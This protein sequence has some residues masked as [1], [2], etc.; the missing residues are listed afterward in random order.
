MT[1]ERYQ[2]GSYLAAN[3]DWHAADAPYKARWIADLLDHNGLKPGHATEIG[4]GSGCVLANLERL[5]P[6]TRLVGCEI[7]RD[8]HAIA[9]RQE[10][11]NIAAHLR[12]VLTEG[13]PEPT[14]L[15]MA[16]DVIEHV[17]DSFAFLRGIR[18][19]AEWKLLHIPLELSVQGLLR[20]RSLMHARRHLG[21]IHYYCRDTALALLSDCG[22]EVRDWRYTHGAEQLPGRKLRT[23]LLNVPRRALRMVDENLSVRVLGGASMLVLAR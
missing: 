11:P 4:S 17:E 22:M 19:L 16:I 8:A 13:L 1:S 5:M 18:E 6:G 15:V 10:S 3:P 2:D 21:H 23:R 7:S 12:D 9:S 20:N 14:E